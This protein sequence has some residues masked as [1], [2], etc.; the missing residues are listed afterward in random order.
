MGG[1]VLEFCGRRIDDIDGSNSLVLGPSDEQK[2]LTPCV[3]DE[4]KENVK[5]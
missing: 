4:N 1:S 5:V 3:T 2:E